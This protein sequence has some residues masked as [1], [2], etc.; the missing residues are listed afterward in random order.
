MRD[1][2]GV[3]V[4][5][6]EVGVVAAGRDPVPGTDAL[7]RDRWS[8]RG[9]V[10]DPPGGDEPVADRGVERGDLLAGVGDHDRRR[11]ARGERLGRGVVPAPA[12]RSCVAGVDVDLVARDAVRRTLRP[13]RS[14]ARMA[15]LSW[16]YSS[17]AT[18]ATAPSGLDRRADEAVH[19]VQGQVRV[20]GRPADG[21][22]EDAAAADRR[23]LVP[24]PD[25]RDPGVVFVGDGQQRAGGVLVEHPGLIDEQQVTGA[26]LRRHRSG[27]R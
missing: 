9:V 24:V 12:S 6:V 19:R 25:Q 14:P 17:S 11:R 20:R 27:P 8:S 10:V 1:G 26:Q 22:V 16:A 3:A 4:R 7:T 21:E 2:P 23:E 13:G 18:V 15:R 5:D